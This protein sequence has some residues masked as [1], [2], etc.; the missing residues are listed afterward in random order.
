M[1]VKKIN[2][3]YEKIPYERGAETVYKSRNRV[4]SCLKVKVTDNVDSF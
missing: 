3:L 2:Y 1:K 4:Y